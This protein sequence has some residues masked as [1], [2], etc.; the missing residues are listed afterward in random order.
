MYYQ[1]VIKAIITLLI[2]AA[3][4]IETMIRIILIDHHDSFTYNLAALFTKRDHV[5]LE[6]IPYEQANIE[7][8]AE[9]DKIIFSPGP[10]LPSEYPLMHQVLSIYGSHKPILGVCLGHQSIG[11]YYGAR[12][13]NLND[14]HHGRRKEL[15]ILKRDDVMY[16]GI[17]SPTSVGVYHSWIVDDYNFP[18]CLN[19]TALSE[20]GIIMSISHKEY[21]VRSV[22]FHPESFLS[23]EGERMINNWIEG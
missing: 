18:S 4:S 2:L 20:D 11:E 21:D 13:T 23:T 6:V 12:I 17:S 16:R 5:Q 8:I 15:H 19:I 1:E 10:G 14:V 22:Q 7:K 9:Y 3:L